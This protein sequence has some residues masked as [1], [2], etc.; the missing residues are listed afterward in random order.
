MEPVTQ[1]TVRDHVA[2]VT[3]DRPQAM[4]ALNPELRWSLS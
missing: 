4:N 2:Y 1:Y 3:L